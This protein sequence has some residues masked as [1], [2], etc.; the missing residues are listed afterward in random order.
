M[1]EFNSIAQTLMEKNQSNGL[2]IT[3]VVENYLGK[4]KKVVETNP[5]QAE[6]IYLINEELKSSLM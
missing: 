3:A 2:K 5:S 4:G 6:F 1:K